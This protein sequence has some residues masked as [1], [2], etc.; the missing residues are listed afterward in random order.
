TLVRPRHLARSNVTQAVLAWPWMLA[1]LAALGA[2]TLAGYELG[3]SLASSDGLELVVAVLSDLGLLADSPGDVLAAL[4][5]VVPWAL[6]ALAGL[7]AALLIL[8]A[9]HVVSRAPAALRV[10]RPV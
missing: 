9:G 2:L 4:N 6:V 8:A 3:A 1:L 7:S 10:R 5:E